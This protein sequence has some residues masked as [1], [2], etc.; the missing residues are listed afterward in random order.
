L[1]QHLNLISEAHL[2]QQLRNSNIFNLVTGEVIIHTTN[3]EQSL[4]S[5]MLP[6][7]LAILDLL[8]SPGIRVRILCL[9]TITHHIPQEA[10]TTK[11]GPDILHEVVV[12]TTT[13]LTIAIEEVVIQI[14]TI[15]IQD[16]FITLSFMTIVN[17]RGILT[18]TP[19]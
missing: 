15:V 2:Q 13:T 14:A 19:I 12:A 5:L 17:P 8:I 7:D 10:H 11:K 1:K 9:R 16:L 18:T 3:Q 6:I 4:I